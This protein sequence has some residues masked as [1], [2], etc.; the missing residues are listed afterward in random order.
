MEWGIIGDTFQKI[1][2]AVADPSLFILINFFPIL[3]PSCCWSK[4]V[5]ISFDDREIITRLFPTIEAAIMCCGFH[6]I[7]L[8]T[9]K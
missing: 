4:D 5:T 6:R 1:S 9:T 8:K 3:K 2:F 7:E